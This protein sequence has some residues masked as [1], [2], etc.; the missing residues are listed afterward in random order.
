M[1][2]RDQVFEQIMGG[3]D[4]GCLDRRDFKRLAS[5]FPVEDWAALRVKANAELVL[6]TYEA[7]D[8]TRANFLKQLASDVDFGFE[9]ALHK[10]GLSAGFM[11]SCVKMWMWVFEDPLHDEADALYTQYGLPFLKA[12]ALKYGLP[13]EIGD[14]AGDENKYSEEGD[15]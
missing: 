1:L 13:N 3:R 2:T 5:Y 10:R 4:T 14:D 15:R 8:W 12:V 9:K 6:A 11:H 7:K